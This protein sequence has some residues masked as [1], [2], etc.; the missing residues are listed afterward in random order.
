VNN[1]RSAMDSA[2]AL[3]F[4]PLER[5]NAYE[6]VR[7][8]IRDMILA[9]KLDVAHRLPTERDL[10]GQFGVSRMVVR[11][12]I[13][14]LEHSGLVS[15]RKGASGG[16]F[17]AREY[18]RPIADS[19]VNLLAGGTA[20]LDHLFEVR[21][22]IEPFAAFRAAE[23]ATQADLEVLRSNLRMCEETG[24]NYVKLRAHNI[25]FHRAILRM[26]CNPIMAVI[27]DAVFRIMTEIIKDIISEHMTLASLKMHQ[28]IFTAFQDRRADEVKVLVRED[29]QITG[30]RLAK[31]ASNRISLDM[32]GL[33][34]E[35]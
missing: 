33:D 21:L 15:V 10:A 32:I 5:K 6:E 13:R 27:G 7:E 4:Q 29:I 11:E 26:S 25:N 23:L 16:I 9:R 28:K 20:D 24:K 2:S 8:E 1:N 14:S 35:W 18:G 31:L 17:V 22:L 3:V 30:Q 19:I 12:A 34:Q